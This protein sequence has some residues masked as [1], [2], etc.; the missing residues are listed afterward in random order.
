MENEA[1]ILGAALEL[2]AKG[3][4][5]YTQAA[6]KTENETGKRMFAQLAKEEEDHI[7]RLKQMFKDLY[8][9]KTDK[10]IPLF[11]VEVSEYSG[12]VEA[13]KIAADMEK[14]SIQF[15]EDWAK[16]NLESLFSV[17]IEIEKEHLELLQA[18]L[19]Y[20]QRTGFWFDYFESSLED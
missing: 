11:E 18:E 3:F 19:D 20:V 1:E 13:L 2:E 5:F 7:I 4:T 14:K 15:Y 17:L 10:D 8:P 9:K 6:K 16:G 12:E